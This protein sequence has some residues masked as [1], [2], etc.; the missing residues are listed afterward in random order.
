MRERRSLSDS[1]GVQ[2]VI[3]VVYTVRSL[4]GLV[5]EDTTV[6]FYLTSTGTVGSVIIVA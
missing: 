1:K 4:Q 6:R 3:K 5:C 2:L